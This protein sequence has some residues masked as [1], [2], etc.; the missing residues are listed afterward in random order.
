MGGNGQTGLT[1]CTLPEPPSAAVVAD[2]RAQAA[3][4][5]SSEFRGTAGDSSTRLSLEALPPSTVLYCC[6]PTVS[7]NQVCNLVALVLS[8][9]WLALFIALACCRMHCG[10]VHTRPGDSALY[11]SEGVDRALHGKTL[12]RHPD[13]Y[14][15]NAVHWRKDTTLVQDTRGVTGSSGSGSAGAGVHLYDT[16]LEHL[17]LTIPHEKGHAPHPLSSSSSPLGIMALCIRRVCP[18]LLYVFRRMARHLALDWGGGGG[19]RAYSSSIFEEGGG[20]GGGAATTTTGSINGDGTAL[21]PLTGTTPAHSEPAWACR[22]L[23]EK[24]AEVEHLS[25]VLRYDL[26]QCGHPFLRFVFELGVVRGLAWGYTR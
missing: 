25:R 24:V 9:L 22:A 26:A 15:F 17:L 11:D 2:A 3:S 10:C 23:C 16:L 19:G 21:P 18:H 14:S 6:T 5:M 13:C 7:A 4:S 12:R 1:Q 20:S 8:L